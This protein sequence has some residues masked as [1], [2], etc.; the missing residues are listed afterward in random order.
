MIGQLTMTL[1]DASANAALR[2]PDGRTAAQA[3]GITMA[4]TLE[5]SLDLDDRALKGGK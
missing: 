5:R 1:Y 3:E 2:R 4:E